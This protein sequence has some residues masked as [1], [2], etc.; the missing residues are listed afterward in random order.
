MMEAVVPAL[1]LL[2][3]MGA[4]L[5]LTL[6]VAARVFKVESD[7]RLERILTALPGANCGS[8]GFPG[9]QGFAQAVLK[10]DAPLTS[11]APGG[12][13]TVLRLAEIL[14]RQ[15][16][17]TVR[18]VAFVRCATLTVPERWKYHY[19]GL[20][21]CRSAVLLAGGPNA[22]IYGCVGFDDCVNACPF[23]AMIA[24]PDRPPLV[25]NDKCTGCGVCVETCPKNLISLLPADAKI[26]VRCSSHD[27]GAVTR[28]H[29]LVGCISCKLCEK[30]CEANAIKIID[31]L[32]RV[33]LELCTGCG[34]CVA[35]CPRKII[36]HLRPEL[37]TYVP[38]PK[39][40][41]TA[42]PAGQSS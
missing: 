42:K 21:G 12:R 17:E 41:K 15:A 40:K 18:Q 32:P 2:G 11:C 38:P 22:C 26:V 1:L 24:R 29:C 30:V 34:A 6:A 16:E 19:E 28:K 5:G 27:K 31:N 14:G 35:K 13:N 37:I 3:G 25:D 8:C 4:A 7:P 9:C 20:K 39:K 10:G 23:D 36:E 33:D